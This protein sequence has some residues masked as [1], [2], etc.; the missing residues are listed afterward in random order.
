MKYICCT[1]YSWDDLHSNSVIW[2]QDS[3]VG[4]FYGHNTPSKPKDPKY[5]KNGPRI[6]YTATFISN[7]DS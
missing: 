5:P 1:I 6:T 2:G 7:V 3:L 4:A